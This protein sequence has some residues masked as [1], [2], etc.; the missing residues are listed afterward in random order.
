MKNILPHDWDRYIPEDPTEADRWVRLLERFRTLH[1]DADSLR[2]LFSEDRPPTLEG[3]LAALAEDPQAMAEDLA[4]QAWVLLEDNQVEPAAALARKAVALH[5]EGE[6]VRLLNLALNLEGE[7]LLT[8]LK[9]LEA[10]QRAGLGEESLR[11][12]EEGQGFQDLAALRLHRG[13]AEQARTHQALEQYEVC[14]EVLDRLFMESGDDTYSMFPLLAQAALY[15][16]ALEVLDTWIE[17]IGAEYEGLQ[18]WLQVYLDQTADQ[19]GAAFQSL[20]RAR[21]LFPQ[22]ELSLLKWHEAILK[23]DPSDTGTVPSPQFPVEARAAGAFMVLGPAFV[24]S[25]DFMAWLKRMRAL[26]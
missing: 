1:P 6:E 7:A 26:R 25:P 9:E 17:D 19:P 22:M 12:M 14:V 10:T 18:E 20:R 4:V 8:A 21:K 13:L 16:G 3:L 24:A 23:A 15:T 11:L 2:A 5:P